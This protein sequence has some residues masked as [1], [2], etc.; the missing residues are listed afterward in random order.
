M[1]RKN[2][3]S[4]FSFAFI[5]KQETFGVWTD[6]IEGKMF[7]SKDYD[8]FSPYVFAI[9]LKDH[10]E[11]TMFFKSAKKYNC[12]KNFIQNFEMGNVRFEN[13]KIKNIVQ[14]IIKRLIT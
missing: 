8:K 7:V 13:Q 2:G 5:Y 3:T 10:S 9:T 6:F 4:K 12:W 14:D 11:N 1:K